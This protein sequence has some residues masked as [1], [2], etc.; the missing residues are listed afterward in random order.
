MT[1]RLLPET[2]INRIAAGE[3]V[4]RPASAVKELVENSI[5]AGAARID[6]VLRDGGRTFIS[7][8][9]DGRGMTADDLALAIERHATSKLPDDD[10]MA[11]GTLGFRGEALPSIGAVSRMT[12]TSRPEGGDSA[13]T[14]SVEGGRK[15]ALKP[16]ALS[17]GTRLEIR[18]LFFATPAR[19]KFLKAE[20][21]EY[22]HAVETINRLAMAHPEIGFSLSDGARR[23]VLY[24]SV[25]GD[26]LD[27][28]L[29]RLSAIMGREFAE[30]A[31]P[32]NA[33]REGARLTGHIGLPTL[34]RSTSA[35]Q[36]LFVNGRPV[37]DKLF[38]GAVRGAYRDFLAS[39]RHPM[40]AL[41]LEVPGETIDVNVHPAKTE[42]RFRD[43]GLVRGLI[44]GGLKHALAD[45]GHRASTTV[46]SAALGAARPEGAP[47]HPGFFQSR[48]SYPSRGL[49]ESAT[50][51]YAPLAGAEAPPA[52]Q[53]PEMDSDPAQ[54]TDRGSYPLGVARGQVHETYIVAQ[55]DDGIVIVDQHAAH[56]RIVQE[57]INAALDRDG[58]ARQGLLIPDVVELDEAAADRVAARADEL[59]EL[60]LTLE[61]FGPGAIVVRETPALLGEIDV[62]GLI[63]DLADDLSE[64]DEAISLKERLADICATM[65]CHG[66]VRAGRRLNGAEMNAL[67]REMEATPHSGQCSHGRPTYVEL[68]IAD[69]EKLFGRR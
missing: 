60:G 8:E 59:A 64:M 47:P 16:A 44:V 51:F 50:A 56:E 20:R 42:V 37:R 33:E 41:F 34:N 66:S 21:T 7:V 39:D 31:L 19:L 24:P 40:L 11:I 6:V 49:S 13:W 32:V 65:A 30:N 4:E 68:K 45:A 15:S 35:M 53:V 48:P 14:I 25:S 58:V 26:L 1:I 62:Q 9:D 3:V 5:D 43:A 57:R 46:G 12:I 18:D 36:F 38:Y 69:I 17:K 63:R 67:L 54:L 10:L 2:V 23:S 22:G 28:R 55:T 29:D 61:A 27:A 52:A